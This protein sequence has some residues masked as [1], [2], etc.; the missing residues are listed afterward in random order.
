MTTTNVTINC[1]IKNGQINIDLPENVS[2]G[3]IEVKFR[4][5][6]DEI[7]WEDRPWTEEGLAELLRPE[8]PMTGAEIVAAGLTG[9]WEHLGIEDSVEWL[10]EQKRKRHE[11]RKWEMD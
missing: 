10:N 1:Y 9:G 3:E 11:K 5:V 4:V 7:P 2:D 8:T 6:Q